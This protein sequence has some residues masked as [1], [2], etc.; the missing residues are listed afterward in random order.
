MVVFYVPSK[1]MKLG[2]NTIPT[3]NRTLGRSMAV[4][5]TT[6]APH[7]RIFVYTLW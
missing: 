2:L 1:H 7:L 6:A 4:H 3:G 5:F